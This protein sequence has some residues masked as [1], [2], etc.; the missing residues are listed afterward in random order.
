LPIVNVSVTVP[1]SARIDNVL[2]VT[3]FGFIVTTFPLLVTP[4]LGNPVPNAPPFTEYDHL[5]I[6]VLTATPI[7]L[8]LSEGVTSPKASCLIIWEVPERF[9]VGALLPGSPLSPLAPVTLIGSVVCSPE[10]LAKVMVLLVHMN[11]PSFQ[12]G[13]VLLHVPPV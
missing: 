7:T 8:K 5:V 12:S 4:L 6:V 13:L 10:G 2:K 9:I 1:S 3:F 11:F